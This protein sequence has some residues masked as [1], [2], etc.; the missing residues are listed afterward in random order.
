[1]EQAGSQFVR[2]ATLAELLYAPL[3]LAQGWSRVKSYSHIQMTNKNGH[4]VRRNT[5]ALRCKSCVGWRE[6]VE[7]DGSKA[8]LLTGDKDLR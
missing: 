5:S 6:Y 8:L 3:S 1:M 4:L 2:G 7:N